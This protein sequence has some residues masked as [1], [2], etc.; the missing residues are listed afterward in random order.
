[1]RLGPSKATRLPCEEG[2]KPSPANMMP[3][4]TSSSLN[5]P[6]ATNISAVSAVGLIPSSES[7]VAL[8]NTMTRIVLSPL[9][10]R[11]ALRLPCNDD[12]WVLPES[13]SRTKFFR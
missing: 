8:T 3:A 1:M 7:S 13:T 2:F 4:F 12:D 10:W 5:L 9:H 11:E 6:I